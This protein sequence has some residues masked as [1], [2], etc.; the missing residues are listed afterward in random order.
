MRGYFMGLFRD[1]VRMF[2]YAALMAGAISLASYGAYSIA[3]DQAVENGFDE[4]NELNHENYPELYEN[5]EE[6]V[7]KIGEAL[8]TCNEDRKIV[9]DF[10]FYVTMLENGCISYGRNFEGGTLPIEFGDALGATIANGNGVCRHAADNLADVLCAIGYDAK[11]VV[12]KSYHKGDQKPDSANHAVVYVAQDGI[13]YL[14]DPINGTI[15]LKKTGLIYYDMR[16]Q[17]DDYSCFEPEMSYNAL[18]DSE[19]NN[20]EL[21][22]NLG[23][24][25]KKHW[26]ILKEYKG[27][28]EGAEDYLFYFYLYE[29]RELG[30]NEK[31]IKIIFDDL[32]EEYN[33]QLEEPE[34]VKTR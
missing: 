3:Y 23:N 4:A 5:Y 18:N 16:S 25:F 6:Y 34:S 28:L 21:L 2:P 29:V 14:L 12:G 7:S 20:T 31:N 17:E 24:D 1:G 8:K 26:E 11:V 19:T 15:L 33:N 22:F 13:G 32:V 27:Y 10:A 9:K 30:E